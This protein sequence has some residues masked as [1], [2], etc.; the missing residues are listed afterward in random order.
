[1]PGEGFGTVAI[2]DGKVEDVVEGRVQSFVGHRP[3]PC[4]LVVGPCDL[5]QKGGRKGGPKKKKTT[6]EVPRETGYRGN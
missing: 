5:I 6:L 4:R 3:S 1:M 2:R